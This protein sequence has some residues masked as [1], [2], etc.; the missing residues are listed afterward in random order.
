MH[1]YLI[2]LFLLGCAT[3]NMTAPEAL[4][5]K[6]YPETPAK[7]VKTKNLDFY[8]AWTPYGEFSNF[9]LFPVFVDGNWWPTSEHYY[10]AQKYTDSK[11]QEWVRSASTPMD[12][13]LRGRDKN[14]PKRSDWENVKEQFMA[15]AVRD[16][17]SRYPTLKNL[18]LSTGE[19]NIF[20][21]TTND[22][23]WGDCGDRTGKNKLGKLL[24]KVRASLK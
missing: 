5:Y 8:D 12:A 6:L 4:H 21:H 20:E 22:C 24:E 1:Y 9:A 3:Q 10:Q 17:F 18:L 11:L 23:E 14:H 16:K 2:L 7:P 19:A 15:K 13:A